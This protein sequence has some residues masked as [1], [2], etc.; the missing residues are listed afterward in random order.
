MSAYIFILPEER[1]KTT[2]WQGYESLGSSQHLPLVQ[3][4]FLIFAKNPAACTAFSF[5][6]KP[7]MKDACCKTLSKFAVIFITYSTDCVLVIILCFVWNGLVRV[8]PV[9]INWGTELSVK[10]KSLNQIQN[11]VTSCLCHWQIN[12]GLCYV[13][14]CVGAIYG[15]NSPTTW[16]LR[17]SVD[18]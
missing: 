1:N 4:E 18:Y 10:W 14:S 5:W 9:W 16:L 8:G 17:T 6:S 3:R 7:E 12:Q 13:M 15:S 11:S 2:F